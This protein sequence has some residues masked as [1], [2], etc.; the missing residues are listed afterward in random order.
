MSQAQA[1]EGVLSQALLPTEP[2]TLYHFPSLTVFSKA[3][4]PVLVAMAS[5]SLPDQ[6]NFP[7]LKG[8]QFLDQP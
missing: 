5:L 8:V 7:P 4:V 6:P 2:A 3:V 1:D